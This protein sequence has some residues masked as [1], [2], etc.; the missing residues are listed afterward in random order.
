[1]AKQIPTILQINSSQCHSILVALFYFYC[2]CADHW[3]L[4]SDYWAAKT[5]LLIWRL[6]NHGRWYNILFS[7][8]RLGSHYSPAAKIFCTLSYWLIDWLKPMREVSLPLRRSPIDFDDHHQLSLVGTILQDG[9]DIRIQ[10]MTTM[11]LGQEL[12]ITMRMKW[13][14]QRSP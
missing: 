10:N 2:F 14:D 13:I 6:D 9:N 3:V 1:M 7:N 5:A 4:T 12:C 11:D 8:W